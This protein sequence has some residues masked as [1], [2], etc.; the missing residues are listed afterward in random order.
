MPS[1]ATDGVQSRMQTV[2]KIRG[3]RSGRWSGVHAN[4]RNANYMYKTT[5]VIISIIHACAMMRL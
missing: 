3:K 1:C 4:L 2:L 5:S